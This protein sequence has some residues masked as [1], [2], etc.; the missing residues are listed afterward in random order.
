MVFGASSIKNF[1]TQ[2]SSTLFGSRLRSFAYQK[3]CF[4]GAIR[5]LFIFSD[6][7]FKTKIFSMISPISGE[8]GY[9]SGLFFAKEKS[10]PILI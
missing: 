4:I 7:G 10:I 3:K 2:V 1:I 5:S 6:K 9:S 8:T